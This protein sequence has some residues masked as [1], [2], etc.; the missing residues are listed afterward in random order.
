M[1]TM[2]ALWV[3]AD[4]PRAVEEA[5]VLELLCECRLARPQR[6]DAEDRGVR[7]LVGALTKVEEHRPARPRVG[8]PE[9]GAAT[10]TG[11]M[12]G[13]GHRRRKLFRRER[14]VVAGHACWLTGEMLNEQLGRFTQRPAQPHLPVC[15]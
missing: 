8:V 5:L 1:E 9:V 3:A 13:R 6:P 11:E 14:V 4:Y 12:G 15:P 10:R 7:V 2:I